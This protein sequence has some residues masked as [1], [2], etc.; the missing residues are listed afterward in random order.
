MPNVPAPDTGKTDRPNDGGA[1]VEHG[2]VLWFRKVTVSISTVRVT[3]KGRLGA[4]RRG[5]EVTIQGILDQ[6]RSILYVKMLHHRVLMK[7]DRSRR[8]I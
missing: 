4:S 5:D 8:H 3:S 7:S 2:T 1:G 6:L